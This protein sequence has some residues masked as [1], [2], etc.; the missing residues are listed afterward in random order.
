MNTEPF[1]VNL[2]GE[3]EIVG[4]W[5][6]QPPF[7][8]AASWRSTTI[9]NRNK[10]IADLE[11]EGHIIIICEN[12]RLSFDAE[13]VDVVYTNS[14]AIDRVTHLGPSPQTSEIQRILKPGGVWMHDGQIRWR[15]P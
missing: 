2:G 5:N 15:K 9:L 11:S 3:G 7:A 6:Q 13:S 14:V 10:T 8:T 1:C 12:D 4:A